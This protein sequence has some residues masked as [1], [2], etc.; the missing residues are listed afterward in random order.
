MIHRVFRV[1][2]YLPSIEKVLIN[3]NSDIFLDFLGIILVMGWRR[4]RPCTE[5]R[6][7]RN[8]G[9]IYFE[10]GDTQELQQQQSRR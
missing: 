6:L 10:I 2:Q 8:E 9:P 5:L 1:D 4:S 7:R 3:F